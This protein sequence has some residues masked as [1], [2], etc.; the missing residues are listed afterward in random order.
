MPR[1]H[2]LHLPEIHRKPRHQAPQQLKPSDEGEG[3]DQ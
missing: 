2:I 3:R 1:R